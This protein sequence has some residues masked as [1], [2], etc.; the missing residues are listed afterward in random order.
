M[1][2]EGMVAV[3]RGLRDA[4]LAVTLMDAGRQYT[5]VPDMGSQ[6]KV[7]ACQTTGSQCSCEMSREN[8]VQVTD[9]RYASHGN[10]EVGGLGSGE[11]HLPSKCNG[12]RGGMCWA[13]RGAVFSPRPSV[14]DD[15]FAN[16]LRKYPSLLQDRSSEMVERLINFTQTKNSLKNRNTTSR[17]VEMESDASSQTLVGRSQRYEEGRNFRNKRNEESPTKERSRKVIVQQERQ[18][19]VEPWRKCTFSKTSDVRYLRDVSKKMREGIRNLSNQSTNTVNMEIQA[20][21]QM[22]SREVVTVAG[23]APPQRTVAVPLTSSSSLAAQQ[24][25]SQNIEFNNIRHISETAQ[26]RLDPVDINVQTVSSA[27]EISL[28]KFRHR[29]RSKSQEEI[30]LQELM[31]DEILDLMLPLYNCA[32]TKTSRKSQRQNKHAFSFK[33]NDDNPSHFNTR[34]RTLECGFSK[35]DSKIIKRSLAKIFH[36]E[37]NPY[38]KKN[39]DALMKLLE[40][41]I[42]LIP[43]KSANAINMKYNKEYLFYNLF[44]Y[45]KYALCHLRGSEERFKLKSEVMNRLETIPLD[46]KG[47]R[48]VF[49]NRLAEILV[50]KMNRIRNKQN[51]KVLVNVE[52]AEDL[53]SVKSALKR[54]DSPSKRELKCFVLNKLTTFLSRW[55]FKLNQREIKEIED[56]L[57]ELLL[58]SK[59]LINCSKDKH[60]KMNIT[61]LLMDYGVS[62]DRATIF[63][64]SLLRN[65]KNI[66][67]DRIGPEKIRSETFIVLSNTKNV[68]TNGNKFRIQ[69]NNEDNVGANIESYTNELCHQID[70]WLTSLPISLPQD[71]AFR[72]VV[73]NDL[74]GDIVDRLRYIDLNPGSRTSDEAELEHLKYQIFKWINK[75]VAEDNLEITKHAPDLMRRIKDIPVPIL[76]RMYDLN[77]TKVSNK[78]NADINNNRATSSKQ[79]SNMPQD[80]ILFNVT[81]ER[82]MNPSSANNESRHSNPD[83]TNPYEKSIQELEKE[84]EQYVKDWVK[85]IPIETKTPEEEA[86]AEKARLGIHNGLWKVV[87]KLNCDP[88]TY[89]NRFFYQDL[90]DEGIEDLLD[91]LPQIPELLQKK[92]ILKARFIAKTTD[93]NDR[94]EANEEASYKY[95]LIK[96]IFNNLRQQGLTNLKGDDPLKIHQDMQVKK[97]VEEFLLCTNYENEDKVQAQIY[98]K[99]LLKH[100]DNFIEDLKKHHPQ[101]L[102]DVDLSSYKTDIINMLLKVRVPCEQIIK[103]EADSILLD[104]EIEQWYN[105][106]PVVP[107]ED[108]KEQCHRSKQR[109]LLAN[110]V[111]EFEKHNSQMTEHDLRI[112]VS[113]F[114]ENTPLKEG[115][116]LDIAFITEQFVNRMRNRPRQHLPTNRLEHGTI[117]NY[118]D[119]SKEISFCSSFIK[120]VITQEPQDNMNKSNQCTN[121]C[122]GQAANA[123]L[124]FSHANVSSRLQTNKSRVVIQEPPAYRTFNEGRP[125]S[126]SFYP[127]ENSPQWLSLEESRPNI[128][129]IQNPQYIHDGN[130]MTIPPCCIP[131]Q[132]R[133]QVNF[134]TASDN[135]Q[136]FNKE[137]LYPLN[138]ENRYSERTK[139]SKGILGTS[140]IAGPSGYSGKTSQNVNN[141]MKPNTWDGNSQLVRR[142]DASKT[143]IHTEQAPQLDECSISCQTFGNNKSGLQIGGNKSH[144]ATNTSE[145]NKCCD[146]SLYTYKPQ[147]VPIPDLSNNRRVSQLVQGR[148]DDDEIPCRCI[149]RLW[150]RPKRYPCEALD[151]FP[152]CLSLMFPYPYFF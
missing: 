92:H 21:V 113:K 110:K 46:F 22:V 16:S 24:S 103:Q 141:I 68:T 53:K 99:K 104:L 69:R 111:K 136:M 116:Q 130:M 94:I 134:K 83:T 3:V 90:L 29:K 15:L 44:E 144:V 120:P 11:N 45:L 54:P 71:K 102:K 10:F 107:C 79:F 26:T 52:S 67:I 30:R 76:S 80:Q 85:L 100:I 47:N 91:C 121:T 37:V 27:V 23:D 135:D 64:N 122:S 34:Q 148:D 143:Q 57:M 42:N 126:S 89:Y 19:N 48:R 33:I 39:E 124:N 149:E 88:A 50:N 96:N 117:P 146:P 75:L 84:Y 6:P 87:S 127:N 123:S 129:N 109:E 114:L 49:E 97:L 142:S 36:A 8:G 78:K 40:D 108:F 105:D 131:E 1:E 147:G 137:Q 51:N 73:I 61:E 55:E 65:F 98:K 2:G 106:L 66:Y 13:D 72:Q 28:P 77:S 138:N 82:V 150:K 133:P 140:Q 20:A 14:Q 151:N 128:Q 95:N 9:G 63:S 32:K 119:F 86:I 62:E 35:A 101:Q 70:E 74:A 31:K 93:I 132:V 81:Q 59:D 145:R 18:D 7:N 58:V 118:E 60:V 152:P 139:S 56:E 43:L 125:L 25:G 5:L 17:P 12:F 4:G 115:E 38:K 41:W 112:E